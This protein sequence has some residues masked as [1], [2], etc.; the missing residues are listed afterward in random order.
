MKLY[1]RIAYRIQLFND[2]NR[3]YIDKYF[4]N[5]FSIIDSRVMY[6]FIV[7]YLYIKIIAQLIIF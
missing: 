5:F 3:S 1:Y 4:Y 6:L 7:E 2:E